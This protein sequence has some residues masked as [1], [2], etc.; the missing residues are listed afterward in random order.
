MCSQLHGLALR[1]MKKLAS[2]C[3]PDL[4]VSRSLYE[5]N[6][7]ALFPRLVQPSFKSWGQES[8]FCGST[9]QLVPGGNVGLQ[10]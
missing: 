8:D 5:A 2:R 1:Q 6:E 7:F 3:G 9:S 10:D 4:F